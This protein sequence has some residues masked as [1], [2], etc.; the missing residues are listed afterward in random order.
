MADEEIYCNNFFAEL[1]DWQHP[2]PDDYDFYLSL[3]KGSAHVLDI[4]CGT[5]IFSLELAKRGHD[6][7]GV[8]PAEAMINIARSNPFGDKVKWVHADVRDLR[9]DERFDMVLM[10][11]NAFQ[12]LTSKE[13]RSQAFRTFAHHLKPGGKFFFDSRNP[14]GKAW[15]GW[16]PELTQTKQ[17]HLEYGTVTRW[18]DASYDETTGIVDYCWTYELQNGESHSATSSIAFTPQEEIAELIEGADLQ[19]DRWLGDCQGS[20]FTSESPEIIPLGSKPL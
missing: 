4:G 6:V 15:E 17:E 18:V 7:V 3:A 2:W 14:N 10:T 11:G 9:L 19:V 20:A 13:D 1:Y 16:R 8:D 5:G 12:A